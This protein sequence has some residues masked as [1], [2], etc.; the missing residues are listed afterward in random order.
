MQYDIPSDD[1]LHPD[2]HYNYDIITKQRPI[3]NMDT[4]RE[5][6]GQF[7]S[8]RDTFIDSEKKYPWKRGAVLIVWDTE[9]SVEIKYKNRFKVWFEPDY[10][11][12]NVDN[13]W[14]Y[15]EYDSTYGTLWAI[16]KEDG[17]YRVMHKMQVLPNP[18]TEQIIAYCDYYAIQPDW[19]YPSEWL[20]IAVFDLKGKFSKTFTWSISWSCPEWSVSGSCSVN[21]NFKIWD[22]IQKITAF[23]L[24]ERDMKRWDK[25]NFKA[26]DENNN[27]LPLQA[28]SNFYSVD[29]LDLNKTENGRN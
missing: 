19:T 7:I 8:L 18:N 26:V 24:I 9:R 22:I 28:N 25:L 27:N 2:I 6:T 23:W 5:I 13:E 12:L 15:V 10:T 4:P 21:V 3:E 16:I 20:K 11:T 1:K 14:P 29:Y 17:R